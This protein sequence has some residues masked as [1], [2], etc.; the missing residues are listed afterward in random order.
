MTKEAVLDNFWFS[1]DLKK[2]FACK[3]T[4]NSSPKNVNL[5]LIMIIT[6]FLHPINIEKSEIFRV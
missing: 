2:S 1:K 6:L 5:S 3:T 4:K